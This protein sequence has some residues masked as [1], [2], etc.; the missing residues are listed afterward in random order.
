MLR[1]TTAQVSISAATLLLACACAVGEP[2]I[3]RF[4]TLDEKMGATPKCLLPSMLCDSPD[5]LVNNS[6]VARVLNLST[7]CLPPERDGSLDE[8]DANCAAPE[9]GLSWNN[10]DVLLSAD[11]PRVVEVT[12]VSVTNTR[13]RLDGPVTLIFRDLAQLS[14]LEL[15]S[16]S[17]EAE[18][19]FEDLESDLV[20]I[21]DTAMPFAGHVFARHASFEHLSMVAASFEL[22]SVMITQ[23]FVAADF[24]S[25][26]DGQFRDAVLDLGEALF[27]PSRLERTEILRCRKLSFFGGTMVGSMIPRCEGDEATR[28]YALL[29]EGSIIDGVVRGDGGELKGCQLGRHHPSEYTLRNVSVVLY[30]M[31]CDRAV[32]LK[33]TDSIRCSHCTEAAFGSPED[34]ACNVDPPAEKRSD[35]KQNLCEPL[36][37]RTQ[38]TEPVPDQLRPIQ[39]YWF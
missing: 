13:V 35:A 33:S 21:G 26:G 22:D 3:D 23:S 6:V 24:M 28:L 4:S 32:S 38:C 5:T 16:S 36:N 2:L 37:L 11:E 14:G 25:S 10:A 19:V 8:G 12:G 15:S 34:D 17:P 20:T 7:A 31:F 9:P 29:A 30:S 1:T 39:D 18:V 27:A